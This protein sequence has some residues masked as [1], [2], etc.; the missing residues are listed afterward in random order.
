[1]CKKTVFKD[2]IA[3]LSV[4]WFFQR[5][6]ID[7]VLLIRHPAAFIA[8]LK[9]KKWEFDF[10]NFS[11]QSLLMNDLLGE[12]R[13]EI[14]FAS[15]N[16]ID[17]I[18][19]GILLWNIIHSVIWH[20][21]VTYKDKWYFVKHEDLSRDPH[22][23]FRKMFQFLNIN[24]SDKVDKYISSTTRSSRKGNL[25]RDSKENIMSWKQRLSKEEIYRIKEGT[26][27]VWPQFYSE[28]E[29]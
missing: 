1:M 22:E 16:K 7:V 21:S 20:Y 19:Q 15:E 10:S 18:E 3:I 2:P 5:I 23:E 17:I 8:S 28:A 11:D 13:Q 27:K 4:E 25:E 24:Y 6:G 29:W 26:L 12:Y 14:H 9:V